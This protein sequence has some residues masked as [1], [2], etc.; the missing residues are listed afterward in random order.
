MERL[1]PFTY[2][3]AKIIPA[4]EGLKKI[5]DVGVIHRDI[6]PINLMQRKQ[7]PVFI[8]F[9]LSQD[10]KALGTSFYSDLDLKDKHRDVTALGRTLLRDKYSDVIKNFNTKL[11]ADLKAEQALSKAAFNFDAQHVEDMKEPMGL[12]ALRT[13]LTYNHQLKAILAEIARQGWNKNELEQDKNGFKFPARWK[14]IDDVIAKNHLSDKDVLNALLG[15]VGN[16]DK[17]GQLLFNMGRC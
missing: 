9:G 10:P 2:S 8:D 15:R 1:D 13:L 3:D 6:S 16:L 12:N 11:F 5:H 7:Q 14:I 4:L 17:Y